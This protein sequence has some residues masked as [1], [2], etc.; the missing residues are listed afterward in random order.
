MGVRK[1]PRKWKWVPL[2]VAVIGVA[3]LVLGVGPSGGSQNQ[4]ILNEIMASNRV[5][6]QDEDGDYPDWIELFNPTNEVLSLEGFWLSDDPIESEMWIFPD[7]TIEPGEYLV[8]F[9]SGKDRTNQLE[10]NLHTNF[11][12]GRSGDSVILGNPEGRVI[13]S[14]TFHEKIPSNISYGRISPGTGQWRYF[15]EPTP[16]RANDADP[17]DEV[18]NMPWLE[19]DFPVYINEFLVTNRSSLEDENGEFHEWIELYNSGSEPVDLTD[20]WLSDKESNPYKWRFPETVIEPDEYLVIFASGKNRADP[21]NPYLHTSYGLNDRD[22]ELVFKTPEGHIIDV[23][24]IRNQKP[25]VSY[26]RNPN[27]LEEWLYFPK[28]NP[29]KANLSEGFSSLSDFMPEEIG[30]LHV[31]EVMSENLTTLADEDGDYPDWIEIYNSADKPILLKGYGLSDKEDN[32][33]RWRLPDV[34]IEPGEHLVVFASRKD[35][36]DPN[37]ELHTNYQIQA[38]GETVVFTHPTGVTLD[39]LHTG[40]LSP[41]ISIGRYPDGGDGRYH[42]NDPTP[43][44]ENSSNAYKGYALLPTAS[45][46]GG[47][48][49]GPVTI[50]L[51][52]PSPDAEIYYTL[53]GREPMAHFA[54]YSR[55]LM[56]TDS[57]RL[58]PPSYERGTRYT[59]PI[60]I[61]ENTVLRAKTLE[62]GKLPSEALNQTYL[63]GVD[64]ELPVVSVHTDPDTMFHPVTGFHA[65]GPGASDVFPH[66]GAN[67]WQSIEVPTH[68]EFYEPDGSL[69]FDFDMGM[70]I[71]GAY[72][73]AE[74]QKSF[75]LFAR[76]VYGYNEF[77]YPFFPDFYPEKPLSNKAITLRTSG[78][79]W[80]FSKIRDIMMTS[81]LANT[82]LD[83]QAHRQSVLYI[84]GEYWGVYNIRER[85]NEHFLAYNHGVDSDEVDLLMGNGWVR[86]GSRTHYD[87]MVNFARRN[88]LSVPENYEYMKTQMDIKN[89]VDYWV[90]Q[91]YFAQTDSANIRLWRE[92]SE[93]G[94]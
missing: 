51:E 23:I 66:R 44:R 63:I 69:G 79:D 53:N 62:A 19:E 28:P 35:R 76:N 70:R 7:V 74:P 52:A 10:G 21:E 40:K 33:F 41:D 65:R 16:G 58:G 18:F 83:Y 45:H 12:I 60:T 36:R 88:D 55:N 77:T 90:A 87:N 13:D 42:F 2:L 30:M 64:H 85:I 14:I 20:F 78:Q 59:G 68:V 93:E 34:T 37:G 4:L 86:S 46:E 67:Y 39:E 25:D 8:V 57:A 29:S 71:A 72:S 1:R 47:M 26:G 81:L 9:A 80:K 11:R 49:D 32:P 48:Y 54:R 75:H 50:T 17:Y 15:L 6:L 27:D 94:R 56:V 5:V 43:G 91:V 92:Q 82:G 22:D 38:T 3:V 24:P 73:R 31:N 61:T 89:Y 84:N